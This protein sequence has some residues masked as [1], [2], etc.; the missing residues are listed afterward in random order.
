MAVSAVSAQQ[1]Q[2]AGIETLEDLSLYMPTL[3]VNTTTAPVSNVYR[4]R[5]I[6][7]LANV[8]SV[9]PAVAIM[10]DGAFRG[11]P[12]FGAGDLFDVER[13]EVLR[14]PQST[15][16][17]KNATAGVVAIHTAVPS[18]EFEWKAELTGG[19]VDGG[20]GD[21]DLYSFKGGVSGPLFGNVRGSLGVS[22]TDQ[23]NV[24]GN[25]YQDGLGVEINEVKRMA[26]R[27]QLVADV[28]DNL[29]V[30]AIVGNMELD[31]MK[32][33]ANDITIDPTSPLIVGIPEAGLPP[34]LATTAEAAQGPAG[35]CVDNDPTNNVGCSLDNV[36]SDLS[37]WEGT[38]LVDYGLANGWTINSI[39]SWDWYGFKGPQDDVAQASSLVLRYNPRQESESWQQELRLTSA[40]G[41]FLDWQVGAFYYNNKFYYGDKGDSAIFRSDVDSGNPL[42]EAILEVPWATPGQLSYLDGRQETDYY[43]VFGQGV[44]NITDDFIV[45]AGARW[46]KEEKDMSIDQAVND[47]GLSAC[48]RCTVADSHRLGWRRR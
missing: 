21:A 36:R 29:T 28:T 40:G 42:W 38:L 4:I 1:M 13:I 2:D 41:E 23:D 5:R 26:F 45:T 30:R 14:G 10:V 20:A 32:G 17:G 37:A 22:G 6:G 16:Y 43:A 12:I 11:R 31:N 25:G 24:M 15:L 19:V 39:T 9:E 44:F 7:N 46:Q 47:A 27:G 18:E 3:E 34:V 48:Q 33:I 8:P 35:L